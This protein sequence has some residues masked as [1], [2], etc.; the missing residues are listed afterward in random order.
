MKK[1]L[2]IALA[3]VTFFAC[4]QQTTFTIIGTVTDTEMEGK[5]VLLQKVIDD[6][7]VAVDSAQIIDGAYTFTGSVETPVHARLLVK[8]DPPQQLARPILERGTIRVVTDER[9]TVTGTRNNEILQVFLDSES[10]IQTKSAE[11][12]QAFREAQQAG[13]TDLVTSLS[14][15]QREYSSRFEENRLNFFKNNINNI[16]GQS[17]LALNF[18][19]LSLENL[20]AIFANATS[21]T[22]QLPE[23]AGAIERMELMAQTA[24]GQPFVD[25]TMPDPNGNYISISDFVGN[26]YLMIDFTATWCGPCRIGKPAMIATFNRFNDRGFNI[27]GVWFDRTHDEWING[28]RA[29]N[30]PDWPQMSDLQFW[31]SEGARLYAINSIPSSVLIDPNGIIIARNLRGDDLDRKL[32]EL[33]GE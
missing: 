18:R 6:A 19:R 30:M 25:L 28:M 5:Y 27:I 22:L 10:A 32:E 2:I 4:Q 11:I 23:L 1:L 26:G 33:L 8:T 12:F 16:A 21:R 29:L 20:Q 15:L 17:Q 24:V 7:F 3:A 9:T 13:D 31:Q 14:E